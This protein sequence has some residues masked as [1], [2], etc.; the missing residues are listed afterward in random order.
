MN[1]YHRIED[2]FQQ[3]CQL[4]DTQLSPDL[5]SNMPIMFDDAYSNCKGS[6]ADHVLV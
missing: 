1:S 4:L 2:L 3:N 5:R 6:P